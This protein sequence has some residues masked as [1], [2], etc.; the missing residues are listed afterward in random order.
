MKSR[1]LSSR[2]YLTSGKGFRLFWTRIWPEV[3]ESQV[4]FT[5]SLA[6]LLM[7]NC[8]IPVPTARHTSD[9]SFGENSSMNLWHEASSLYLVIVIIFDQIFKFVEAGVV[10]QQPTQTVSC[11]NGI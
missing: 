7:K 10:Y 8:R 4:G 2:S 3:T 1:Y 11:L 5:S 9:V 6:A